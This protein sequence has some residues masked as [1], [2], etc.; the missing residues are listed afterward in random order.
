ML[1]SNITDSI[2]ILVHC[3]IPDKIKGTALGDVEYGYEPIIDAGC[4]HHFA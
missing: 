4:N 1:Y 3:E 2:S